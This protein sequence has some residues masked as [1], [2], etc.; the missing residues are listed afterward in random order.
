[1]S[2][3]M[4]APDSSVPSPE[5][6]L[7]PTRGRTT[8]N[9]VSLAAKFS[10]SL[11]SWILTSTCLKSFVRAIA[12]TDPISTSLYLTFVLPASSPSALVKV[13][14]TVGPFSVMALATSAMPM[15]AA[16]SGM[17]QTKDGIQR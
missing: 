15:S 5:M 3:P 9:R 13:T 6:P 4:Y 1:M 7:A 16:I 10:A 2:T 14:V 11:V 17:S 8:Q 12:C